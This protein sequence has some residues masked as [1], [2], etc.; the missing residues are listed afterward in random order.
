MSAH[1]LAIVFGPTLLE[2]G[3]DGNN[4]FF[5]ETSQ[6][7]GCVEDL[8]QFY[9]WLFDVSQCGRNGHPL[10]ELQERGHGF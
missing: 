7:I 6:E 2:Y 1:N 9:D 8:L 3:T 10:T 4:Q 5:S